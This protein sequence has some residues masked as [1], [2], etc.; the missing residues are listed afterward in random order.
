MRILR[1]FFNY[2]VYKKIFVSYILLVSAS[3]IIISTLLFSIFSASTANEIGSHSQSMLL[4]T[5]YASDI[6]YDQVFN[7]NY[8]LFSNA[9][10]SNVM[11]S[12][13][14][15]PLREYNAYLMLNNIKNIYPF[16][17]YIGIYNE[18]YSYY[19]NTMGLDA[20]AEEDVIQITRKNFNKKYFDFLPRIVQDPADASTHYNV[21]DFVFYPKFTFQNQ[22][23]CAIVIGVDENYIQTIIEGMKIGQMG[24]TFVMNQQGIV[25]SH[26]SSTF[27][28]NDFSQYPYIKTI[29][30]M[31]ESGNFVT[32]IDQKK[33]L[34][35]YTKSN[36][37]D[38]YFINL[39][40]YSELIQNI[41]AFRNETIALAMMLLIV[42]IL[43]SLWLTRSIYTPIR[44]LM[45]KIFPQRTFANGIPQRIDEFNLLTNA[46]FDTLDMANQLKTSVNKSFSILKEDYLQNLMKGNTNREHYPNEIIETIDAQFVG[47]F[48]CVIIFR[49]DGF[50]SFQRKFAPDC[51]LLRISI[52]K[53]L[54]EYIGRFCRNDA[55]ITK[56]D[57][58]AALLQLDSE[59][60][61]NEI[62]LIIGEIQDSL[63]KYFDVSVSAGIG[64]VVHNCEDIGWTYESAVDL[65]NFRFFFGRKSIID[66]EMTKAYLKK[67][68]K[69]PYFIEKRMIEELHLCNRKIIHKLVSEFVQEISVMSYYQAVNYSNQLLISVIKHFE[70]TLDSFE[71]NSKDFYD[72]I[73]QLPK[74][75]TLADVAASLE[76]FCNM[77]CDWLERRNI[78]QIIQRNIRHIEKV[79]E[80]VKNNYQN[81][82]L[83]LEMMSDMVQISPGYLGK[84]FKNISNISF[85]EYLIHT[86]LEKAKEFLSL[87][88]LP[89]SKIGENV[90]IYNVTYFSTLFK[91]VYGITPSEFRERNGK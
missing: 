43:S 8:Q 20:T 7:I 17:K 75:E 73:N 82:N 48:Y 51:S 90:G 55:I 54:N 16:I 47:P 59:T 83:S 30:S 62:I 38:W 67:T 68:C 3:I 65:S 25:L 70:N 1:R 76:S 71:A 41:N 11:I 2:T 22:V 79:Q 18:N 27:F 80:Y 9:T 72:T 40:G 85:T 49:I 86:R 66:N 91:K 69:Y 5:S 15:D 14:K 23:V 84:L 36:K 28:L 39:S 45:D 89:A 46:F 31:A 81:P 74:C 6:I 87:T 57:E 61:A 32:L 78:N 58:F 24:S 56:D 29:L 4:Q 35:T 88:N 26:T 33:Y 44:K 12:K 53:S 21:L 63:D 37:L 50:S 10:I 13:I 64:P 34:V 52:C 42:G 77:I 60:L 19:L